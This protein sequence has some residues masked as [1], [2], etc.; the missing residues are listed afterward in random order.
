MNNIEVPNQNIVDDDFIKLY[1]PLIYIQTILSSVKVKIRN[2]FISPPL[3]IQNLYSVAFI[4]VNLV[5]TY[6]GHF[7][8]DLE[9]EIGVLIL[10]QAYE[11]LILN[12]FIIILN[13]TFYRNSMVELLLTLQT[14]DRELKVIGKERHNRKIK[15]FMTQSIIVTILIFV[16]YM[17]QMYPFFK[18]FKGWLFAFNLTM[19]SV[20]DAEM[21]LFMIII[22]VVHH[23]ICHIN[24][25]IDFSSEM[26]WQRAHFKTQLYESIWQAF[27]GIAGALRLVKKIFRIFV[28]VSLVTFSNAICYHTVLFLIFGSTRQITIKPSRG[29]RYILF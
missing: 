13:N 27:L 5:L 28:S 23:R 29:K 6:L 16:L 11:G 24:T 7:N 10:F 17:L 1:K 19:Y 3:R 12:V 9:S 22:T 21:I 15:I 25:L 20:E 26:R 4:I 14:V 2:K 18:L 8:D